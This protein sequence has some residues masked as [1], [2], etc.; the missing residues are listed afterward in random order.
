MPDSSQFDRVALLLAKLGERRRQF[1][2]FR[3]LIEPLLQGSID[4]VEGERMVFA[5]LKTSIESAFQLFG[6]LSA[7]NHNSTLDKIEEHL[8]D[9]AWDLAMDLTSELEAKS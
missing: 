9:V 1:E 7:G 2:D 5:D 4:P 8:E 3:K 6:T